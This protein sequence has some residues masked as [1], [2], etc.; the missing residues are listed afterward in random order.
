MGL[1]YLAAQ[2][3]ERHPFYSKLL[4][5][6]ASFT[7]AQVAHVDVETSVG[8][9]GIGTG[10]YP[11]GHGVTGNNFFNPGT[12]QQTGVYTIALSDSE[13][14]NGYPGFFLAPTLSDEWLKAR[15]HKPVVFALAAA[16]RAS[17]SMGGHGNL[18]AGGQK[19]PVVFFE[20]SGAEAGQYVTDTNFYSVPKAI[21]GKK[22]DSYVDAFLKEKGGD[23]Y[24]HPLRGADGKVDT[25]AASASPAMVRFEADLVD[26]TL[27]ELGVGA[28]DETDLIWIN[29]KATDYCG[30]AYGF[31]S[32]EC[33]DV[34]ETVNVAA[35]RIA[36][37][38]A[39][40]T[41]NQYAIV[42]TADH[43]AAPLP[44]LSGAVRLSR[45]KLRQD[46]EE[47]FDKTKNDIDVV[48]A[49]VSSQIYLNRPELA[50]NGF[51]VEDVAKFL[52]AYE[53]PLEAP[54]NALA[55]V[56]K[57]RGRPAKAR[58]F[59]DVVTRDAL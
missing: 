47:R 57:K 37:R 15:Q 42:L 30:H 14:S 17:I 31:E 45:A 6:G 48:Q 10:A 19:T 2:P 12:W 34:L 59:H 23:W 22:I 41:Q 20:T 27:G 5:E 53:A 13:K 25:W 11:R 43:G 38:V 56:W 16:A 9:A 4:D 26:A 52:R 29:M 44:E 36:D 8:H 33:G 39:E 7:N 35:K 50:A 21:E 49:I 1:Q 54:Y 24:G 32:E 3:R 55:D 28:D 58:F 46:L 18:F 51:T 40:L